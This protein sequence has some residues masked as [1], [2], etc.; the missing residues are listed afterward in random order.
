MKPRAPQGVPGD[1]SRASAVLEQSETTDAAAAQGRSDRP[2]PAR[3]LRDLE[4]RGAQRR[5][6][7]LLLLRPA[8]AARV[9]G[10]ARPDGR[11]TSTAARCAAF[12]AELGR[13]GYAPATL[14]RKLSTLRGLARYLTESRRAGRDPTRQPARPAPPPPAA[15][16]PQRL[17]RRH[18]G[19][20]DRGHGPPRPARP[21][22]SWS[23]ST[24]AGC[25][26]WSSWACDLGDV[27]AAQAQLIVHG[28]GGKTRIV[29]LGDEAAA[30]LRRYL[31]RGRGELERPRRRSRPAASPGDPARAL[32]AALAE[33]PGAAHV[34]RTPARSKI[35]SSLQAST[36]RRLTCCG[37][38]MR[39]TCWR[40]VPIF[41]PFRNCS[42]TRRCPTTQVYTHVSGAHLR[43]TYDLHHPRA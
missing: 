17:R 23:C 33:R 25:A 2:A 32:A 40:G 4:V 19:R 7:S 20:G 21:R 36:R 35:Q 22:R 37:T 27:Q 43:R 30:A 14:A 8:A 9:A 1:S 16:R 3:F 12:S 13:R 34:G 10:R 24:G 38:R 29:P 6:T 41:V 31:E 11:R 18:A 39:R 28:K 5:H 26:A 15:A 42:G